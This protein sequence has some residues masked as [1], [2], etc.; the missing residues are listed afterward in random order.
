MINQNNFYG[1]IVRNIKS[2]DNTILRIQ[3]TG[4]FTIAHPPKV[5]KPSPPVLEVAVPIIA[6]NA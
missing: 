1:V 2:L 5:L 4:I 3:N 6:V